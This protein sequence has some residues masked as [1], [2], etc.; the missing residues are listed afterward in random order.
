MPLRIADLPLAD[1]VAAANAAAQS[2]V[3]SATKARQRD[4]VVSQVERVA[5]ASGSIDTHKSQ[6]GRGTSSSAAKSTASDS[7]SVEVIEPTKKASSS[8]GVTK[9]STATKKEDT[10]SDNMEYSTVWTCDVCNEE[11]F[12][13]FA[14]AAEHEKICQGKKAK[15]PQDPSGRKKN[16]LIKLFSPILN[17]SADSANFSKLS[18][19]HR[20]VLKSLQ[21][22]Y[23][24]QAKSGEGTV[25]FHCQYCNEDFASGHSA[26]SGHSWS[27]HAIAETLPSLLETHLAA[28]KAVSDEGKKLSSA[29]SWGMSFE[30]FLS[31]FFSENGIMEQPHG[32]GVVVLP[33]GDFQLMPGW[34]KSKRGRQLMAGGKKR[35]RS[36]AGTKPTTTTT[37]KRQKASKTAPSKRSEHKEIKYGNMG[38]KLA[39]VDDSV[40]LLAPIDGIP[41]LSSFSREAS[42][43]LTPSEKLLLQQI[44]LFTLHSKLIES[45][46]LGAPPQ[47]VGIRCRSCIANRESSDTRG[48]C[49]MKLSSVSNLSRDVLLMAM[50][51]VVSCRLIKAKDVK[52]IKEV[53]D[54][55]SGELKEYCNLISKLYSLDDSKEGKGGVVWGDSPKV[56]TGY[57]TPRDVD[58]LAL[59]TPTPDLETE[60]PPSKASEEVKPM[61]QDGAGV[62]AKEKEVTEEPAPQ[63]GEGWIRQSIAR[64]S[65]GKSRVDHYYVSP[66][67][68]KFRSMPEVQRYLD[69][70]ES[71][72]GKPEPKNPASKEAEDAKP[73]ACVEKSNTTQDE[74]KVMGQPTGMEIDS[75]EELVKSDKEGV[76]PTGAMAVD[77]PAPGLPQKTNSSPEDAEVNPAHPKSDSS[78][79]VSM[80]THYP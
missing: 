40:F 22:L 50:E 27:V 75:K 15:K 18:K 68:R 39:S 62:E 16:Q 52:V 49:F 66:G 78:P 45:A 23:V 4:S 13:S 73:S 8:T 12:N 64:S 46:K 9:Q 59:V 35:G 76:T 33:S 60:N 51:H 53:K 20:L 61:V 72:E 5:A 77:E 57:S 65:G 41:F 25:S 37:A 26:A 28:C 58:G 29:K 71:G 48:C 24:P 67:G 2:G 30:E 47:S 80:L 3:G 63:I 34:E 79:D 14:E 74:C 1:K 69:S 11:Q 10:Q 55:G 19:Y 6:I 21:L 43:N 38:C 42:K 56:P 70:I 54:G 31:K 36:A 17:E 32:R 7:S 44:E